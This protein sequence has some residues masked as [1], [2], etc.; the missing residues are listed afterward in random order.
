MF[1]RLNISSKYQN[2]APLIVVEKK[3]NICTE[4]HYNIFEVKR[5][6]YNDLVSGS[7]F[8]CFNFGFWFGVFFDKSQIIM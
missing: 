7:K 8:L 3:K 2:Y 6:H 5:D 4:I 1:R